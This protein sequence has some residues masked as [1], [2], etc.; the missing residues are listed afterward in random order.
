MLPLAWLRGGHGAAIGSVR[1]TYAWVGGCGSGEPQPRGE[2][3]LQVPSPGRRDGGAVPLSGR[4][5]ASPQPEKQH[6]RSPGQSRSS[7]Q[8]LGQAAVLLWARFRGQRPGLAGGEARLGARYAAGLAPQ[9]PRLP[10]RAMGGCGPVGLSC[11]IL[12]PAWGHPGCL[13][14]LGAHAVGAAAVGAALLPGA[15]HGVVVAAH[16]AARPAGAA[17][18]GAVA[19]AL[20]RGRCS[21]RPCAQGVGLA[22]GAPD[23]GT[24]PRP[25]PTRR[26][27]PM[28]ASLGGSRRYLWW[29][30]GRS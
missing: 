6:L 9:R 19:W 30:G 17:G 7:A 10:H 26:P 28:L 14:W 5:Q 12:S 21:V 11:G 1:G 13:T 15:A 18:A 3:S 24:V 8:W 16:P 25:H 27:V 23:T 2:W 29:G 20:C 4:A 22:P